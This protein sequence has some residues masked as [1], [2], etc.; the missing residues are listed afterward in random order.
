MN[1]KNSNNDDNRILE[2]MESYYPMDHYPRNEQIRDTDPR[3]GISRNELPFI[4]VKGC[5]KVVLNR[6]TTYR[7]ENNITHSK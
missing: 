3:S 2:T 6:N 4:W 7:V 5:I 1:D